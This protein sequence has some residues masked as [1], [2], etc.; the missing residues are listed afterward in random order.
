MK[1]TLFFCTDCG[2]ETNKWSGKCPACGSWNTLKE[3]TFA[4]GIKR[5]GKGKKNILSEPEAISQI[6]RVST[7]RI[8]TGNSEFDTILGGGLV[9][10]MAVLIG[11]EPGIGKSTLVMQIAN[12]IAAQGKKALYVSGEES[13]EQILLRCQR[14]G[15][16]QENV[17]LSS[18]TNLEDIFTQVEKL[19]PDLII[20]DSIQSVSADYLDS[21]PGN[22][23]QIRECAFALTK[24]AK[25]KNAPVFIIGHVTKDGY[26]AGPKIIEHMVDTVLYF[27]IEQQY[28]ILRA[29]KNRF[30]STNEIG[31]F[32]MLSDGL[33]EVSNPSQIFIGED[34][35]TFGATIGAMLEGT[36]AFLTEVQAL[37]T[38]ANYGTPQR[39]ALGVEQ[40]K[41]A[42]ILA[43]L[44]KNLGL[45]LRNNDVFVKLSGGRKTI[46]PALDLALS[47]AILS[48][49]REQKVVNGM[50]FIGEI[51]LNGE[52]RPVTQLDKRLKEAAKLGFTK[53]VIS[54]RS[55]ISESEMQLIKIK[56]IS[57]IMPIAF[58]V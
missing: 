3:A 54:H 58:G 27:E 34:E 5:K 12:N 36:R 23:G 9:P 31:I 53:A 1:E 25:Q 17:F 57:E 44:E 32:E 8:S 40:K 38:P 41:L 10:G 52:A 48:S 18:E 4:T 13:K 20:I 35:H 30:G 6:T 42:V 37:V 16:I 21:A 2:A 50:I 33:R 43:V 7:S 28:R 46:E 19:E 26:V 14:I 11:G 29:T 39:V 24:L 47:A 15:V 22:L 56:S 49:F 45:N 51:G 55:D